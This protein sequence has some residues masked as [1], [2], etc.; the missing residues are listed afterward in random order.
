MKKI[1]NLETEYQE[2]LRKPAI[3]LGYPSF[4]V[5]DLR[6]TANSVIYL[7]GRSEVGK[8]IFALNIIRQ[9]I[10]RYNQY[11]VFY[12]FE[13]SKFAVM[14]LYKRICEDDANCLEKLVITDDPTNVKS[15][16][17]KFTGKSNISMIFIDSL[18][19]LT[20]FE[21]PKDPYDTMSTSS[22]LTELKKNITVP[23]CIICHLKKQKGADKTVVIEDL[24]GAGI[25]ESAELVFG[26]YRPEL[27]D[28]QP[29]EEK[30]KNENKLFVDCIKNRNGR[31]Y[32][33]VFYFKKQNLQITEL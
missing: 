26:M 22:K 27:N 29:P 17:N 7:A 11:V 4:A 9:L 20:I 33:T 13:M 14:K 12:S 31:H 15:I 2:W 25:E 28:W 6:I 8:T 5:E 19:E 30:F 24:R 32:K 23:I 3:H 10:N 1:I 18:K 16:Q 21:N